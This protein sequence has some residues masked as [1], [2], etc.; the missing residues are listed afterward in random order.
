VRLARRAGA[1]ARDPEFAERLR[2]A[3]LRAGLTRAE[4]AEA[5]GLSRRAIDEYETGR[6]PPKAL[7]SLARAL[8]V[9]TVWLLTGEQTTD[10]QLAEL[11]AAVGRIEEK[12]DRLLER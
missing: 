12:I 8:E 4:L 10:K 2:T 7:P 11:Q 9:S 6:I 1:Y 3:R 5:A